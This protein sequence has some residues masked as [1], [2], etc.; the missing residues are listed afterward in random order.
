MDEDFGEAAMAIR[1]AM[2]DEFQLIVR[3]KCKGKRELL[4]LHSSINYGDAKNPSWWVVG[5]LVL[6]WV[7]L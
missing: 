3:Q 1:D 5:C 6:S 7:L 2:E 4:N